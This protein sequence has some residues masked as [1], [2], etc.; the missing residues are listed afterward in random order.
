MLHEVV[1]Q[2]FGGYDY[3]N[4][5]TDCDRCSLNFSLG[6]FV[7]DDLNFKILNQNFRLIFETRLKMTKIFS[8]FEILK[9]T[10]G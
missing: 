9:L 2:V 7:N 4:V 6:F 3:G 5:G 10:K 1:V 8:S